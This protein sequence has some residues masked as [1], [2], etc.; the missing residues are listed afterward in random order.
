M[1]GNCFARVRF[2]GARAGRSERLEKFGKATARKATPIV[3]AFSGSP[4]D[5]VD[6][7]VS[8]NAAVDGLERLEYLIREFLRGLCKGNRNV[9]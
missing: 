3:G 9:T 5:K 2:S 7:R 6:F 4:T 8:D 1:P